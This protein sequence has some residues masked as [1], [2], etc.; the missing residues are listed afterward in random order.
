MSMTATRLTPALILRE[1]GKMSAA[2]MEKILPKIQMISTTRR[3]A[4]PKQ[5]AA[6]L[7][8]INTTLPVDQRT[9]YRRLMTKRKNGTLSTIELRE[10]S[11]LTDQVESLH[12]KRVQSLVK[13]A[14]LRQVTLPELMQRLGLKSL[15]THV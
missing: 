1:L 11:K 3:G 12:A 6:L 15:A 2:D 7:E 8:V 9:V 13:L 4:L 5:E 14:A 10:L